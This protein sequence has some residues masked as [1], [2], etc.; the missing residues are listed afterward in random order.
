[1]VISCLGQFQN[2]RGIILRMV[3][4][5]FKPLEKHKIVLT[6]HLETFLFVANVVYG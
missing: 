2:G 3:D 6:R 5:A 4:L 1:M